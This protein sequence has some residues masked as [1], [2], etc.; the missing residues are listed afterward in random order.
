[1]NF[2][3]TNSTLRQLLGNG[4]RY[5]V[6]MFQRDYSWDSDEWDDLWEDI[7]AAMDGEDA[8]PAHYM[9]YLVLQSTNNKEFDVIDGQ[10]RMTTLSILILAAIAYLMDL[11]IAE[12][13]DRKNRQRADQLRSSYIGYLDPVTLI[14]QSK[15]TL[16]RNNDRFYQNSLVPLEQP[17]PPQG[18]NASE[19]LLRQALI[20]FEDRIKK[21]TEGSG[22]AV[23]R[24]VD[25]LVDKLF[26]TVITITDELNAFKVFETLNSRGVRLSATDLLKN[27]LFSV[28]SRDKPHQQ[29][30]KALEDR[31]DSI[32]DLLGSERF[33]EFLRTFWNSRN[34]LVRKTEL[35]KVIRN[36]IWN[37][38]GA[39]TLIRQLDRSAQVYVTL[40]RPEQNRDW[41][42]EERKSLEQLK[43]FNVRQP[44]AL[45]LA[46]FERFGEQDRRGFE[47]FLR[48]MAVLSFRYNVICGRQ[49]K[50]QEGLYNQI[51]QDIS[52]SKIATINGVLSRL[53]SIYPDDREFQGAFEEK[54]L[55]T[56]SSHNK[57]VMRLI[58]FWLE[59]HVSGN[60]FEMED[61]R[62][63]I[64][65]VL[66]ENPSDDW[67]Q[68]DKQEQEIFT[69]RLGNMTL[70][71]TSE[72]RD[73]GNSDYDKKRLIYQ[74]SDFAIT[75]NLSEQYDQWT[76][77]R[78]CA[79]QRWM[80]KQATSIWRVDFP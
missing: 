79:N 37:R 80:A 64:E 71:K 27:Y 61:S 38:D 43:M 72:N 19:N 1:M 53:R 9:G 67:Y 18:L 41:S 22:V 35:F 77:E 16:N 8:E 59:K 42:A 15:L 76:V 39:F 65:H 54:T 30:I 13:A 63:N 58:L 24:F 68:F 32:V 10:Q 26:F 7:L 6:P 55:Q 14:P 75:R 46:V 36:G 70:L 57:N 52:S 40:R 34:K 56:T 29:D 31:W 25:A 17:L 2:N 21:Q 62:Y 47:K 33:P 51:A 49:G 20:W 69:Y 5:R 48:A 66:P 78:I 45:L 4:L 74:K 3:T 50:E 12:G 28:V 11:S 44:L 23:A 60:A 73:L